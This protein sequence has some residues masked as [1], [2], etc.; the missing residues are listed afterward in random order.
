MKIED[1]KHLSNLLSLTI[2]TFPFHLFHPCDQPLIEEREVR[3]DQV[4][5]TERAMVDESDDRREPFH[6]ECF[7]VTGTHFFFINF[8]FPFFFKL[9]ILI[10]QIKKGKKK[11]I[12]IRKGKR[13][14]P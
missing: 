3:N 8:P 6:R 1:T 11:I 4:L 9:L 2:I 12:S 7:Y 14:M 10:Y 5:G 13:L